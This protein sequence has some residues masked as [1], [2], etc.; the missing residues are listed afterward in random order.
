[1]PG[2]PFDESSG[3][4]P[5]DPSGRVLGPDDEEQSCLY[6]TGWLRRGPS[7]VISTNKGDA[8][9]VVGTLLEDWAAGR[10]CRTTDDTCAATTSLAD[11]LSSSVFV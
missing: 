4:V 7:G 1:M 3:T 10:S 8:E 9:Q 11:F 6:A 2:L 5:T